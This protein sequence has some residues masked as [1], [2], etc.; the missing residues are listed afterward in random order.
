MARLLSTMS[1]TRDIAAALRVF[2]RHGG[3]LRTKQALALG[4]PSG[5]AVV[6]LGADDYSRLRRYEQRAFHVSELPPDVIDEPGNVAIPKS[7]SKF[8]REYKK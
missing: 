2:R 1:H 7:S 4:V 5:D 8:D 3:A 6:L